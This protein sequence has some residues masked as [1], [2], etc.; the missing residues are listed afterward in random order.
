MSF[1]SLWYERQNRAKG[2]RPDFDALDNWP[3]RGLFWLSKDLYE[4]QPGF[5]ESMDPS[6]EDLAKIRNHLEHRYLKLHDSLW[7][8]RTDNTDELKAGLADRVTSVNVVFQDHRVIRPDSYAA[9]SSFFVP[10]PGPSIGVQPP[11]TAD[12]D[13]ALM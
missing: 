7:G 8:G 11:L 1:R 6:G 3:L 5:R 12:R 10:P 2:L 13:S 4:D 9:S